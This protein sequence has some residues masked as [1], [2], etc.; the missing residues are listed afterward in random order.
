MRGPST[1]LALRGSGL[2]GGPQ[3]GAEAGELHLSG[4]L[5]QVCHLVGMVRPGGLTQPSHQTQG[6]NI[7]LMERWA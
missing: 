5:P 1:A 2:Q 4:W 7:T 3:P 6:A